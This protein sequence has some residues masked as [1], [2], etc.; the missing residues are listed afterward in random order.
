MPAQQVANAQ[1]GV[2]Q[3]YAKAVTAPTTFAELEARSPSL[4]RYTGNPIIVHGPE[5]WKARQVHYPFVIIDPQDSTKLIMFYGGGSVL[6]STFSLGRATAAKSNPYSWREYSGNPIIADYKYPGEGLG[7]II[8]PSDV[9]WNEDLSRFELLSQTWNTGLTTY[10]EGLYFSND[11]FTW[12]YEGVALG[13]DGDEIALG[14]TAVIR[15]TDIWYMYYCYRTASAILPGIRVATS[16]NHGLTWTKI[17]QV[18]ST[19]APGSYDETYIEGLSAFKLGPDYVLNYGAAK[20]S[21]FSIEYSGAYAS[22]TSPTSGFVK[23]S[24]NP[25]ITKGTSGW[26]ETQ[27]STA[28]FCRVTTPW[29][30]YYQGTA[31]TG[32]YNNALWDMGLEILIEGF[33]WPFLLMLLGGVRISKNTTLKLKQ[34]KKYQ[35][36]KF[37]VF[38]KQL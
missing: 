34:R 1:A 36:K 25:F 24:I 37:E 5:A 33:P 23:S 21:G 9:W 13:P 18:L 30:L 19:G 35:P 16:T 31:S 3:G 4:V 12:T 27:I 20:G 15:E 26:D 38:N 11:G 29:I 28:V 22:S 2:L 7:Y 14:N 32:D 6:S 17:G 10:W 8:G